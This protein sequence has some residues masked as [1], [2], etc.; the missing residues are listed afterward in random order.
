[1]KICENI[2][3]YQPLKRNSLQRLASSAHPGSLIKASEHWKLSQYLDWSNG[4]SLWAKNNWITR[5]WQGS[6]LLLWIF[7][8]YIGYFLILFYSLYYTVFLSLFSCFNVFIAWKWTIMYIKHCLTAFLIREDNCAR[9]VLTSPTHTTRCQQ[10][11][12]IGINYLQFLQ[13]VLSQIIIVNVWY[14]LMCRFY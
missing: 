10:L 6:W 7:S 14:I 11:Y 9:I 3:I 4:N 13:E 5:V 12:Q 8:K 2:K 1:M